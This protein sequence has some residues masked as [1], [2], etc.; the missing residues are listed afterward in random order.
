[1][2]TRGWSI[3][4]WN[5]ALVTAVFFVRP[6]SSGKGT[7]S[8]IDTTGRLFRDIAAGGD[9]DECRRDFLAAFGSDPA[10][11]REH[12]A[13]SPGI[14]ALTKRDGI[15]PCFA[16]LYLSLLAASADD[17]TYSEGNFR[18]RFIALVKAPK[19]ANFSFQDLP[20][21]WHH[22]AKWSAQEAQ[23][24]GEALRLVLPDPGWESRIGHA[25]RLAFPAYKD[26]I[27]LRDA[28]SQSKADADSGF[29]PV[30]RAVY[31]NVGRFSNAF[32]EEL[33]AFRGHLGKGAFQ[34]AY[35][36]PFWGAVRDITL[37]QRE[38]SAGKDG[39]FRLQVDLLDPQSPT[40]ELLADQV[41]ASFVGPAMRRLPRPR[42]QCDF[43][44]EPGDGPVSLEGLLGLAGQCRQLSRSAA[45]V[46]LKLGAIVFLPDSFG[47]LCTDGEYWDGAP[48]AFLL[49][50]DVS[51]RM[52]AELRLLGLDQV[53]IG[54]G[55]KPPWTLWSHASVSR[56]TLERVSS[57]LPAGVRHPGRAWRPPSPRL[58]GGAWYGQA[59][60]LNPA[61]N[62]VAR[63]AGATHGRFE[64]LRSDGTLVVGGAVEAFEDGFA[65]PPAALA[66]IT[67]AARCRFELVSGSGTAACLDVPV[68]D[69]AP[70][71]LPTK[72]PDASAWLVAGPGGV[73]Q[74]LDEFLVTRPPSEGQGRL[75][76]PIV[77][78]WPL[79]GTSGAPDPA[80]RP[81][82]VTAEPV[83]SWLREALAVR[84]HSRT[85]LPFAELEEHLRMAARACS[86]PWQWLKAAALGG[87]WLC[88]AERRSSPYA[89]VLAAPRCMSVRPASGR[90]VARITGLLSTV[91]RARVD[92]WLEPGESAQ[93][94][95]P[96]VPGLW[97]GAL[98]V[99]LAEASRADQLARELR[100]VRLASGSPAA[101]W[102]LLQ[103]L[104]RV[105][106]APSRP[107]GEGLCEW[108]H[109][110]G[111]MPC[112]GGAPCLPGTVVR[113]VGRQ[114]AQHW[115]LAG[116]GWL[117]TDTFAWAAL[118][119][120]IARD[121]TAGTLGAD[122]TA[123][124][125]PSIRQLPDSLALWWLHRGGGCVGLDAYGVLAFAG[126]AALH[127]WQGVAL[128][129]ET[130]PADDRE[131][132]VALRR[133]ALAR[134]L[135]VRRR[136]PQI[137]DI[138]G[139]R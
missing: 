33:E 8:R 71:S 66:R 19:D 132:E 6:A 70:G 17:Q 30:S 121:G 81:A 68:V 118:L 73:L 89:S 15:P 104:T 112:D 92:A 14:V 2:T 41:G 11:L 108:R 56:M 57:L 45:G 91:D 12:F 48:V 138:Q 84:L 46:G 27:A 119:A 90:V 21:L 113:R 60:L 78:R 42:R 97:V 59:L 110:Q 76:P 61:S 29:D 1:M 80:H 135:R 37:E 128:P 107:A 124:W 64:I 85:S 126:R 53:A 103:G 101:P 99:S 24:S 98:E 69:S 9:P 77:G 94:I 131:H 72:P 10:K 18:T 116:Q 137:H 106:A 95:E 34:A 40:L 22:V 23:R 5:R 36:S 26:E 136:A 58:A 25:K 28:L 51:T 123:W 130:I 49:R 43:L 75:P 117:A 87:G 134:S 115:V 32:R 44:W 83:L 16:A 74:G 50:G 93:E 114:R 20:R 125:A 63:M 31:G 133:L 55:A 88:V 54:A 39:M 7:L 96:G 67:D 102:A 3:A 65:I 122:G 100:L 127:A 13:W 47:V 62:P 111:W 120:A 139:N 86:I 105:D 79:L 82:T 109:R 35:D 38:V 129:T 4:E 52:Q